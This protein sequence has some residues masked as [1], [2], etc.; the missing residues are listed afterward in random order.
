MGQTNGNFCHMIKMAARE[1]DFPAARCFVLQFYHNR[2]VKISRRSS[3]SAG[4]SKQNRNADPRA[5]SSA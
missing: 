1:V 3:F 4:N 2:A 5:L